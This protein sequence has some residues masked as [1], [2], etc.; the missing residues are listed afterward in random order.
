MISLLAFTFF[1]LALLGVI[2]YWNKDQYDT[3]KKLSGLKQKP[4]LIQNDFTIKKGY[5]DV[6]DTLFDDRRSTLDVTLSEEKVLGSD[7]SFYLSPK[8]DEFFHPSDNEWKNLLAQEDLLQ[9]DV[10]LLKYEELE[11]FPE[12]SSFDSYGNELDL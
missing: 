9:E 3:V 10:K 2:Y 5:E 8:R 11:D 1:Y 6:V 4:E 12:D 7:K